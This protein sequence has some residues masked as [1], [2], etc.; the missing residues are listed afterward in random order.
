MAAFATAPVL[1]AER[2]RVDIDACTDQNPVS[3]EAHGRGL[4]TEGSDVF[5]R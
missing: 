1:D 5:T 3:G 2:F 4:M